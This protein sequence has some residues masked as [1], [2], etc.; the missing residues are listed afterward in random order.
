MSVY[1]SE[2][3]FRGPPQLPNQ[4]YRYNPESGTVRAVADGFIRPNGI[5]VNEDGSTVYIIDTGAQP[6][7]GTIDATGPRTIY[8]FDVQGRMKNG[9]GGFL[10]N[11][12][13][14]SMPILGGAKGVKTDTLGNVYVGL[15]DGVSVFSEGGDLLGKILIDGVANIGFGEPGVL[16]AMGETKLW[17]ID[18]SDKIVGS[19]FTI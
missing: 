7:D 8:A 19:S 16:F 6:G 11:R 10:G 12:R 2:Y 5:G 9:T 1:G 17:R 15:D 14:F 13:L 4:V 3:G 18:L